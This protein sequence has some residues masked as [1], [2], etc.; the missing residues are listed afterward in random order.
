[1]AR[2]ASLHGAVA[3]SRF[4]TYLKGIGHKGG[5]GIIMPDAATTPSRQTPPRQAPIAA[6][7]VAGVVGM[8]L[9]ATIALWVH[10]GSAV[11][12]EML[13]SGLAACF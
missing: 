7:I 8:L 5:L 6:I 4:R 13:L 3:R 12:Y 2:A 10:Y 11:F 1:M 9:A